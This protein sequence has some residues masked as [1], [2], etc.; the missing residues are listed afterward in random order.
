MVFFN[1]SAFFRETPWA[2]KL[3]K[4]LSPHCPYSDNDAVISSGYI[5]SRKSGEV[6]TQIPE[7]YSTTD[8]HMAILNILNFNTYNI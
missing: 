2:L 5:P 6:N 8:Y 3:M 4:D 7:Y 1:D